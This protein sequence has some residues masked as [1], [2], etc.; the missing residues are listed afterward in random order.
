MIT[1]REDYRFYL[2]A[3]RVALGI[4][5]WPQSL[6]HHLTNKLWKYEKLLRKE[7]YLI[8]CKGRLWRPLLYITKIRK[9]RLGLKIGAIGIP[10]NV[11][12]PG[13]SIAHYGPIVV[14]PNARV[15]KNCRIHNCVLIGVAAAY[16]FNPTA[17]PSIGDNVFIGPGVSIF[18]RITVASDIAIGA[19]SVVNRSFDEPGI[20]V[21]GA[22]AK[23]IS[24]K[25]SK[26]LYFRATELVK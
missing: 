18:G 21:A 26:D 22:P 20:T 1:N 5:S 13:L 19:N 3:D 6:E 4:P 9:S 11:F 7:E 16:P 17:V 2:K 10:P 15:G 24:N 14:H 23:K 25:G 12:G 8:N